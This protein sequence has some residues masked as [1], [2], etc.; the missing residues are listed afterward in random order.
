MWGIRNYIRCIWLSP[1]LFGGGGGTRENSATFE[2]H[3]QKKKRE[4][5]IV[6][7]CQIATRK[8][9]MT[10]THLPSL[11]CKL[12]TEF[13]RIGRSVNKRSHIGSVLLTDP[14]VCKE[15]AIC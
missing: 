14:T 3:Y 13:I 8:V 6:P 5:S 1:I 4:I 15:T 10:T 11:S 7:L 9:A 2:P 12:S